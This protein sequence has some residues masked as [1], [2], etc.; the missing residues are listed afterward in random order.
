PED[1]AELSLGQLGSVG[2]DHHAR[3]DRTTDPYAATVADRDPAR[4]LGGIEERREDGPVGDRVAPVTQVLGLARGGGDGSRVHVVTPQGEGPAFA[5]ANKLVERQSDSIP[6]SEPE[7]A[8]PRGQYLEQDAVTGELDPGPQRVGADNLH[9]DV[10]ASPQIRW[11]SREADPA[12]GADAAGED[13][14][15]VR[16]DEPR[17]GDCVL[18]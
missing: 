12:E 16:G 8:N 6:L 17:N 18:D 5:G 2:D 10:L 9:D 1:A 7:P 3:V 11:I 13:R 15:H 4:S 14:S